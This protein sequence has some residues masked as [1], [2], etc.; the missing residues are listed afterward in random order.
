MRDMS[1]DY[2]D[3]D[4]GENSR[5]DEVGSRLVQFSSSVVTSL[6]SFFVVQ[7]HQQLRVILFLA[8]IDLTNEYHNSST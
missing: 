6:P 8:T 4:G 2:R 3:P 7:Y 1:Y 5:D